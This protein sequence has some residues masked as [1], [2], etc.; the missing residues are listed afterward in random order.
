MYINLRIILCHFT[1]QFAVAYDVNA[2]YPEYDN[3]QAPETYLGE[4]L[5][6]INT[7][8]KLLATINNTN[9]ICGHQDDRNRIAGHQ[10]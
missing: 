8:I 4:F 7:K 6:P 1:S 5:V 10:K 9:H 2:E 3:F